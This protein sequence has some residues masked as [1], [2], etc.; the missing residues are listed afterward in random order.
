[1]TT[2]EKLPWDDEAWG[3]EVAERIDAEL[4]AAGRPRTGTIET[5][6]GWGRSCLQ[7]VPTDQGRVWVK[8]SYRLPPGEEKV[9]ETLHRRSARGIP[10]I[11]TTWPGAVA[12]EEFSGSP[13]EETCARE[14]WLVVSAALGEL[15]ASEAEHVD[16][17][18]ALGVR[19]RRPAAW[20]TAVESLFESP[21]VTGLEVDLRR[22]FEKLR[23]D[24]IARYAA[25]FQSPPTLIP[26]DSGCCNVRLTP[27]G[28]VFYDWADVVVG[29][30]TFSCD[31]LLDQVPEAW[32]DEV[33]AALLNPTGISIDEFRQMRRSNVLH[34]ILRYHD[35]LRYLPEQDPF[36]ESLVKS[37]RSQIRVLVDHERAR[38]DS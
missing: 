26:Q 15:L 21:V 34:E 16:E 12:M 2:Q 4:A 3:R 11:V 14:D 1:M 25:S 17:W 24:F 5:V 8:H 36:H 22:G 7:T 20:Q 10:Q 23:S 38:Q 32:H 30:A 18:L 13:M 19:D 31:R 9:L 28:P 37:I 33:T 35:E 29:H 27:V 6:K